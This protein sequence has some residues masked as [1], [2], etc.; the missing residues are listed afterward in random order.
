MTA[1]FTHAAFAPGSANTGS[2]ACDAEWRRILRRI[3]AGDSEVAESLYAEYHHVI[4]DTLRRRTGSDHIADAVLDVLIAAIRR[5]RCCDLK[6]R[7][8]FE[9]AIDDLARDQALIIR[10]QTAQAIPLPEITLRRKGELL[11]AVFTRLRPVERQIVLRAY[12]LRHSDAQIAAALKLSA[13]C[14]EGA[15]IKARALYFSL[16][17]AGYPLS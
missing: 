17:P 6:T 7:A 11:N 4:A 3:Y 5:V 14:V 9:Q 12:L 1:A 15:R 10:D 16:H 13:R 2:E 8:E